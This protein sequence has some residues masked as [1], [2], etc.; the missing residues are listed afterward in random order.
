M[1]D[2]EFEDLKER[3]EILDSGLGQIAS[4]VNRLEECCK[5]LR[6]LKAD[7]KE[8]ETKFAALNVVKV[9]RTKSKPAPP[10]SRVR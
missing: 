1:E 8:L 2:K 5:E 4:A 10:S 7:K 6:E 3:V 9:S